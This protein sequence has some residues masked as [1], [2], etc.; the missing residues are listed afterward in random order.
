MTVSTFAQ[1]RPLVA[2]LP[3]RGLEPPKSW[4][5][6]CT[7]CLL[8]SDEPLT[9]KCSGIEVSDAGF[10][11]VGGMQGVGSGSERTDKSHLL[12]PAGPGGGRGWRSPSKETGREGSSLSRAP[13]CPRSLHDERAQA[14]RDERPQPVRHRP[15]RA[16]R[17]HLHPGAHREGSPHRRR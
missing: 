9:P 11:A 12:C 14:L 10:R 4:V 3:P 6:W 17:P 8:L 7:S 15:H 16:P 1:W 2:G 5:G 13:L